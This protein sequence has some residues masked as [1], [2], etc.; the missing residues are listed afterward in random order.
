MGTDIYLDERCIVSFSISEFGWFLGRWAGH[1]RYLKHNIYKDDKFILFTDLDYHPFVEDFITYTIELPE[2][3]YK[4]PLDRDCYE[5]PVIGSPPGSLTPPKVYEKLIEY[6]RGFYNYKKAIEIWPPR[7]CNPFVSFVPQVYRKLKAS[8]VESD[9]PIVVVY[10]RKRARAAE[11]NVPEFVWKEVVDAL[12]EDFKVVLVGTPNG[13]AL[14]GYIGP[15]I[16]NLIDYNEEDKMDKILSYFNSAICS[17]GSQSGLTYVSL[18]T[19]CPS[20]IIGHE[21]K[22]HAVDENRFNTP[23]SFRVVHDYRAIDSQTILSDIAEM[24]NVLKQ[25]KEK[26]INTHI[27]ILNES[28]NTLNSIVEGY[29]A[30]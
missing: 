7:G 16:V 25:E 5:A 1:L 18:Q 14:V 30:K 23:V 28:T 3:F 22:R 8:K 29:N 20:Y 27:K 19:D 26:E 2:W 12:T 6:M 17:V 4:T 24:L 21:K 13:S 11:R 10:P 9:R 15:N